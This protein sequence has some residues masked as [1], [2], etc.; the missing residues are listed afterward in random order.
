LKTYIL[1]FFFSIT[2]Y[3]SNIRLIQ[4]NIISTITHALVYNKSYPAVYIDDPMFQS[5]NLT[6]HNIKMVKHC[7]DADIIFTNKINALQ[8]SCTL[9]KDKLIFVLSYRNYVQYEDQV[10]GAFFWQ[11]GRP[12]II[13]NRKKLIELGINLPK[14][15]EK[16]IE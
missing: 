14:Q 1:L 4:A 5:I 7:M 11:K 9:F 6:P 2:L 8:K 12:N 16:Y 13:F 3:A 10:I 15:F